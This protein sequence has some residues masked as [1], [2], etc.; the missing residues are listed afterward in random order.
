MPNKH[1]SH[2]LKMENKIF[3]LLEESE[4]Y[5]N[6]LNVK[7]SE[8]DDKSSKSYRSI[9]LAIK[10]CQDLIYSLDTIILDRLMRIKDRQI[11]LDK[12]NAE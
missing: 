9:E 8:H 4:A 6:Y 3:L 11:I 1:R 5:L 10:E 7:K 2:V 12:F